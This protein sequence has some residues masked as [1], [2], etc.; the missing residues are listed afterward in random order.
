VVDPQAAAQVPAE[1]VEA[2][3]AS[4]VASAL[5]NDAVVGVEL[6]GQDLIERLQAAPHPRYAVV[7]RSGRVI[8]VLDWNDVAA[9]V[10]T[11]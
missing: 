6:T 4:A 8:G 1:R 11:R 3:P 7:D 10:S 9:F 5:G 2:V